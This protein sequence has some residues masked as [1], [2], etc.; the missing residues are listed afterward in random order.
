[1]FANKAFAKVWEVQ[2]DKNYVDLRISTS[3]KT[4]D[5]EYEQDFGGYVRVVGKDAIKQAKSLEEGDTIQI[6]GC[7]VSNKYDKKKKTTYYSFLI[8]E[9]IKP[10]EEEEKPKKKTSSRKSKKDEEDEEDDF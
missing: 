9:F 6:I 5:G 3:R 1:M 10:D 8:F 7:G 2:P 4:D